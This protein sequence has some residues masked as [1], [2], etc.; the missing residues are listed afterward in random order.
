MKYLIYILCF[1]S[2]QNVYAQ[3]NRQI[4]SLKISQTVDSIN[5]LLEQA[6]VEKNVGILQ[7]H[8]ADDFVFTHSTGMIDN[9]QSWVNYI[10]LG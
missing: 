1:C 10:D 2:L 9:K 6:V 3:K 8:Y 7:K 5:R 4:N